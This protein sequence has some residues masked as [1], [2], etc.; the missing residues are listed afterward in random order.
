[1]LCFL[2]VE[3]DFGFLHIGVG[4]ITI[5]TFHMSIRTRSPNAVLVNFGGVATLELSQGN[6]VYRRANSSIYSALTIVAEAFVN[7]GQWHQ[8]VLDAE[9]Y[10][11][12]VSDTCLKSGWGKCSGWGKHSGWGKCSRWGF[13]WF[14]YYHNHSILYTFLFY[15]F[16]FYTPF[17]FT[18]FYFIHLSILH[19]SILYT[20]LFYIFLFYTPFYFIHLSILHLSILYTFLF[21]I[22][23]FYTPFYFTSFYFIHHC[24]YH[25]FTSLL[26][27]CHL[28][29][30]IFLSCQWIAVVSTVNCH[31]EV[32][33]K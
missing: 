10:L 20:F 25:C 32:Q 2:A 4:H 1:M 28:L 13:A 30:C 23:L 14:L 17:Y 29:I 22:F 12:M 18:S 27:I 24:I 8:I 33:L 15:I 6:V 31:R 5:G 16:L 9:E 26:F 3:F 19:L 11:T 7:D 21:Y